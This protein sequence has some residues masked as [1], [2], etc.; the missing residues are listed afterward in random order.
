MNIKEQHTIRKGN[1]KEGNPTMHTPINNKGVIS[2][3]LLLYLN[4]F[5]NDNHAPSY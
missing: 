4:L 1:P 2:H 3:S 5:H